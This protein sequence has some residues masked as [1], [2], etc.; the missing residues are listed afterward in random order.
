MY[1]STSLPAEGQKMREW[2][3]FMER[4]LETSNACLDMFL[5]PSPLFVLLLVV[6]LYGLVR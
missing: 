1:L 2:E 5:A 6:S 4:L 3:C